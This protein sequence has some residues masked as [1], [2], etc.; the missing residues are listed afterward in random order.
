LKL[1]LLLKKQFYRYW[2]YKIKREKPWDYLF[3]DWLTFLILSVFF[4]LGLF[5]F[6][7]GKIIIAI[8]AKSTQVY[9]LESILRNISLFIGISFSFILLSFNIF[10]RYFGRYA[11]LDFFKT[12]SAKV[13]LTLL[14]STIGLLVYS[15][16]YIR[17]TEEV[18]YF[19]KFLYSFSLT[20]SIVSFFS[21]FPCLLILLRN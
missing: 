1:Q 5:I 14:V 3:F 21:V 7:P 6:F 10:F 13:C 17:E 12:K 8:P 2:F 20:L 4:L 11:F 15:T 19:D 9:I 16:A 18:T